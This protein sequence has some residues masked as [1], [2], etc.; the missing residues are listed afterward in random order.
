MT[1]ILP[2]VLAALIPVSTLAE[3]P[4]SVRAEVMIGTTDAVD[5]SSFR[6]AK[7]P[8]I[9]FADSPDDPR[10]AQQMELLSDDLEALRARDVVVLTD[11]DPDA[12][13]PART[14][15]RP[16]GFMMVLIGKEGGV[17]LRKPLPWTVREITRT[18][19]KMPIRQREVEERRKSG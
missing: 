7:R 9:V 6:W 16:R 15:L 13:S 3:E 19:D 1:R 17:K 14:K 18:I 4:V 11:T 2:F 8:I 10:F 5:L 12:R